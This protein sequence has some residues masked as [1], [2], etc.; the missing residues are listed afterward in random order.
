MC[1]PV[2]VRAE[3]NQIGQPR[4][5]LTARRQRPSVV[6]LDEA[7]PEPPVRVLEV[8]STDLAG[9]LSC[10]AGRGLLLLDKATVALSDSM[11]AEEQLALHDFFFLL[12]G[13]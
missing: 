3:E 10:C 7:L 1:H 9:E 12:L 8:E 13:Q 2:A 5:R 6:H 11:T 4:R